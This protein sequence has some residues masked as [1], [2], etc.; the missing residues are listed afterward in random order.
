MWLMLNSATR[1]GPMRGRS[2]MTLVVLMLAGC[3]A[4]SGPGPPPLPPVQPLPVRSNISGTY[5]ARLAGTGA[6]WRITLA[7]ADGTLTGSYF[8]RSSPTEEFQR[9][10][11]LVGSAI[12]RP[13][14]ASTQDVTLAFSG[15]FVGT[16][17]G[18]A[19]GISRLRGMIE[20]RS[21]DGSVSEGPHE[22]TFLR[23]S[24]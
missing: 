20:Y 6:D 18:T 4:P 17:T 12:Q 7:D 16:F 10:G 21:A 11:D 8:I 24:F 23:S 1:D 13:A 9:A 19:T 2:L 3:R 22:I 15:A 14:Q 5:E